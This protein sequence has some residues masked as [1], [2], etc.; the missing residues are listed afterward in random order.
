MVSLLRD[1]PR[2]IVAVGP[3]P[4]PVWVI[5]ADIVCAPPFQPHD[6][7]VPHTTYARFQE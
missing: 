6:L 1:N 7:L 5:I 4:Q 2:A 3:V